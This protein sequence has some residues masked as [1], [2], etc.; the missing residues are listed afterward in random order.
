M[1]EFYNSIIAPMRNLRI[2]VHWLLIT[3]FLA[4]CTAPVT[5]VEKFSVITH[6][7]GPLYVSDQVSFEVLAPAGFK[8]EGRD[9]QIRLE[10]KELGRAGFSPFGVGGRMEATLWWVWDTHHLQ[11][12]PVTLT[13]TL[14]PDGASWQET[15]TLHPQSGVPP[16]EPEARWATATSDCCLLNYITGSAAERDMAIL[17]QI[18]DE[19]AASLASQLPAKVDEKIPVVF[20]P[21]VLGHGGFISNAIYVSYLDN[22]Y[23]GNASAQVLGHEFAHWFDAR[24]GGDLRPSIFQEGLAVYLSGGHFKP[25]PLIPRAAALLELNWYISLGTLADDFYPQQHEIGY[26]E[27]AALVG[28]MIETYGWE[29]FNAFYRDIHA[30]PDGHVS[31]AIDAALQKHFQITFAELEGSYLE[32]L[33]GQ[34]VPAEVRDDLRSSVQ[35]YDTIRR[36]QQAYDPSAYFMTAWLPDYKIM[37]Q[38]GIVADFLRH[39]GG[40]ENRLIEALL[41]NA[42]HDLRAGKFERAERILIAVNSLLDILGFS[43]GL[44]GFYDV[45]A[46]VL[47]DGD[48]TT[49]AISGDFP[50]GLSTCGKLVMTIYGHAPGNRNGKTVH[51]SCNW[52]IATKKITQPQIRNN[53][54]NPIINHRTAGFLAG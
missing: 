41:V 31:Q 30:T 8:P 24:L 45:P 49:F 35:F 34:T 9:V 53:R 13:F 36:Y 12:G 54:I 6:P 33:R 18:A 50:H 16:P 21:R 10:D 23:L 2:T 4:S 19:Q 20:M 38:R 11:P 40:V 17:A 22:D 43:S 47:L 48:S 1:G 3:V 42:A 7:D 25:E 15:V 46:V 32:F 52:S 27:A 37:R 29:A 51:H 44:T 26:L 14:L 28:Y 39:P 5:P